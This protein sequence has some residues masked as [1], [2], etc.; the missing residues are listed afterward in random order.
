MVSF[1]AASLSIPATS[2]TALDGTTITQ[3]LFAALSHSAADFGVTIMNGGNF[4]DVAF[5]PAKTTL[6]GVVFGTS[7]STEGVFGSV[8]VRLSILVTIRGDVHVSPPSIDLTNAI[9][10]PCGAVPVMS[11]KKS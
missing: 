6:G 9:A 1:R 10:K 7:A 11:V 4:L 2:L 5:D 3:A 8:T